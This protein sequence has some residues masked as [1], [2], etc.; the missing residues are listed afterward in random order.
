MAVRRIGLGLAPVM[1]MASAGCSAEDMDDLLPDPDANPPRSTLYVTNKR[2]NDLSVVDLQTGT[3]I[4]RVPTCDTPHELALSPDGSLLAVAC[5]GSTTVDILQTAGLEKIVSVELGERAAPHG[6]VWMP[7]GNLYVT[8]EGRQSIFRLSN[9]EEPIGRKDEFKTGKEGSH[10]LAV[11]PDESAAWTTDLSSKTVTRVDL[12][13]DAE[14][15]SVTVGEEPEGI[16]LTPDGKTLWVSARGSDQAFALDPTT[17]EV[18][19]TVETGRFPLRLLVRP[20]GDVAITSDLRDGGLTVIDLETAKV[21]RSIAVSSPDEAEQSFQVTILWSDNGERIYVAETAS[22]TVAEV[23]YQS[24]E[25]LRRL[26]V[27]EGGDGLAI[28]QP[29]GAE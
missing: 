26:E 28:L 7:S 4:Q 17:M 6:I 12:T 13:G 29:V 18:R 8:A 10:M 20:Q 3:E 16:S 14:P 5:Y 23:D 27:G 9:V 22:N 25:V 11:A 1:L 19:E 15:L 24:G 2:G 21:V